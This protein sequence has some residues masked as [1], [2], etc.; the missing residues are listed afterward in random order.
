MARPRKGATL[1]DLGEAERLVSNLERGQEC[2]ISVS[3]FVKLNIQRF[4]NTGL[5]R[6]TIYD[7]LTRGG[8]NLGSF[9]SF[10]GHWSRA[11]KSGMQSN[12]SSNPDSPAKTAVIEAEPVKQSKKKRSMTSAEGKKDGKAQKRRKAT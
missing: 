12:I 8:L 4:K 3:D 2:K 10:S 6:Q 7:N 5:S 9:G 1:I 11:E